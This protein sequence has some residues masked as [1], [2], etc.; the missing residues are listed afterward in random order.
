MLVLRHH[1]E[2]AH[3]LTRD[4]RVPWDLARFRRGPDRFFFRRFGAGAES[5]DCG[6]EA[7]AEE[8][9]GGAGGGGFRTAAEEEN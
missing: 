3:A 1:A 5:E 4:L 7:E 2:L 8:F 6:S 9:H